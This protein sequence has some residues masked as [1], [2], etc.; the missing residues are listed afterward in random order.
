LHFCSTTA[1]LGV[2]FLA[3]LALIVASD[4][5][6]DELHAAGLSSA[7]LAVA[8]LAKAVPLPVTAG[9]HHLVEEAHI[10]GSGS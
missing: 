5:R 6:I 9:P 4:H 3:D 1:E 2:N 8:V 7:V 10:R